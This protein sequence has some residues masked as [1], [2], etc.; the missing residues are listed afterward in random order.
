MGWGGRV[1]SKTTL[2]QSHLPVALGAVIFKAECSVASSHSSIL[3]P[4][5]WSVGVM[6]S[7]IEGAR[8]PV[9]SAPPL[10]KEAT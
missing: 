7:C 3:T 6:V 10:E 1:V 5:T 9:K 8:V 4:V 2:S